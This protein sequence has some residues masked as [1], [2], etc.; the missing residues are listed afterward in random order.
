MAMDS[1]PL[2]LGKFPAGNVMCSLGI[3]MSGVSI[4][5]A[6]LMFKHIGLSMITLRTYFRHQNRFMF[7]AI[8]YHWNRYRAQLLEKVRAIKDPV[9]SGDARFDSMGHSAKYGVYMVVSIQYSAT[10]CPNWFT[11]T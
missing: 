10:T 2:M 6:M 3:L 4:S 5:K 8:L 11:L 7:P 9:Y 1:Q